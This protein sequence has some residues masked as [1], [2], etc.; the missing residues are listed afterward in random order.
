MS[1]L[2]AKSQDVSA[3]Q[4][5]LP[6]DEYKSLNVI[7]V[8]TISDLQTVVNKAV[9]GDE[10]ILKNGIYNLEDFI[11]VN[12]KNGNPK[13]PIIIR[14][15][16]VLGA[17]LAGKGSFNITKSS[18]IV[19]KGFKFVGVTASLGSTYHQGL[20]LKN[21]NNCRITRN[22]FK[23]TDSAKAYWTLITGDGDDHRIDHN[24]YA[25]KPSEGC[26]I[27]VYGGEKSLSL[28]TKI[29]RNYFHGQTFTGENGGEVMRLGDSKR[30]NIDAFMIVE[31][32]LFEKNTGDVEVISVK[33]SSN[34]IRFNTLRNNKGSIVLRHGDD[35]KVEGNFLLDG[36]N[37]VRVYGDDHKIIGNY[38]SGNFGL[39]PLTTLAIGN[40][41]QPDLANGENTYDQPQNVVIAFNTFAANITNVVFGV[42]GNV[43]FPPENIT[44]ANNIL[45]AEKG[46]LVKFENQPRN[47][48]WF[49]NILWGAA[50]NGDIPQTGFKRIN[51]N[52][53]NDD[54]GFY[55]LKQNSPAIKSAFKSS[56]FNY[57]TIDIDGQNRVE[58]KDVGADQFSNEKIIRRALTP[59]DVGTNAD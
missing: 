42:R 46:V 20:T 7:K 44:F 19:I 14:A 50:E 26:F 39:N 37:G 53:S 11:K 40:G 45:S 59:K 33:S 24:E 36:E 35:N 30:Q 3:Q 22:Y 17:T 29:D 32:N 18:F 34:H 5:I 58:P 6:N 55:R 13:N 28:R 4:T 54:H 52:L 2:T 47:T 25:D 56:V 57:L 38:F 41:T 21:S 8:S 12:S 10:I 9:A 16:S 27:V 23:M 51:P 1:L 31:L 15:E 43:D 49:G 48:V